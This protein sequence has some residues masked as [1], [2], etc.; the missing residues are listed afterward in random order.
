MTKRAKR[1]LLCTFILL[2]VTLVISATGVFAW[3]SN[4]LRIHTSDSE[5]DSNIGMRINLLFD[6]L[7]PA[8]FARGETITFPDGTT[9]TFDPDA[10][11]GTEENPYI[12]SLPRHMINLYA[13]QEA[14]YFY[15]RYISKNYENGEYIEDSNVKPYF[16]VCETD[17]TPAC[18]DGTRN[19]QSIVI[20]PVGN[21]EYP[22]IGC[23]GGAQVKLDENEQPTTTTAPNGKTSISSIIANFTVEA[24]EDTPDIGLFGKIGYLGEE[25]ENATEGQTFN[26]AVSGVSDLLLYDVKI[27]ST[28]TTDGARDGDHLWES[29]A[30]SNVR[31]EEDH[32]VGIL[33]GHIEYA[34]IRNISVYYSSA[35][36]TAI[37][38][39]A[40]ENANYLSDS[41][42]I[43]LVYNLN[44]ETSGN[45]IGCATGTTIAGSAKGAGNEWGASIDML[46]MYN[47]LLDIQN[48]HSSSAYN[49]T[50]TIIVNENILIGGEPQVTETTTTG[51]MTSPFTGN[52]QTYGTYTVKNYTNEALGSITFSDRSGTNQYLYLHDN[53][54]LTDVVK[55]TYKTDTEAAFFLSQ[56]GTYLNTN[57]AGSAVTTAANNGQNTK[58]R[59]TSDGYLRTEILGEWYYLNVAGGSLS[60]SKTASTAWTVNADGTVRCPAGFLR[61]DGSGWGLTPID[62]Y[63]Y[64]TDGSHYLSG[65]ANAVTNAASAAASVKWSLSNPGGNTA[66]SAYI[67][68]ATRYLTVTDGALAMGGSAYTWNKDGNVYYTTIQGIRHNLVYDNGWRLVPASGHKITDGSGHYLT[69]TANA[70]GN[71]SQSDALVWQF[72]NESGNTQISAVAEGQTRYLTVS[73]GA[74]TV[75]GT[76]ATWTRVGDSFYMTEGGKDYYLNHNGSEWTVSTLSYFTINDGSGNYLRVTGANAFANG[77]AVNATHFYFANDA[78]ANSSGR[79]YC[80]VGGT[81]YYLYNNNGTLATTTTQNTGTQWLNDGSS[82]YVTSTANNVTTTYAIEYDANWHIRT[83]A[84][85]YRITDGNGN[86]MTVS[87]TTIGSTTDPDQATAFEFSTGGANPA[88]TIRVPGTNYY[89]RNNNGTLQVSTTSTTWTNNGTRLYY[90]DWWSSYYLGYYNGAWQLTT[91]TSVTSSSYRIS[92]T[93][94]GVTHYLCVD[95]SGNIFDSTTEADAALWSG[96][97]GTIHTVVNGTTYYLHRV[98][99]SSF[100]VSTSE[101]TS[102]TG[103]NNRLSYNNRYLS[104][105]DGWYMNSTRNNTT[106]AATTSLVSSETVTV[107]S[108]A[109]AVSVVRPTVYVTPESAPVPTVTVTDHA[110]PGTAV[111]L[112]GP[113]KEKITRTATTAPLFVR[114]EYDEPAGETYYP[115]TWEANENGGDPPYV[116]SQKNTGYVISGGTDQRGDI[117][118]SYYAKNNNIS[119]SLTYGNLDDAKIYTYN[120]NGRRTIS[121]VGAAN[122]VKY[123]DAKSGFQETLDSDNTNVYGLHFM[124]APISASNVV[125]APTAV[126]NGE[127]YHDYTMPKDCID[128]RLRTKGYINFFAGTY[129]PDNSTFFSLHQITRDDDG[130]ITSIKEISKIYG[131]PGNEKK[132]YIYQFVGEAAPTLPSG[133]E[134]IFD[135]TWVTN[136]SSNWTDN[137]IYYYEIPVNGGE[138]A[139]GSVSGRDGAYLMYLDIG[140]SAADRT[141]MLGTID[142]VYDN[143]VR[144]GNKIVVVPDTS[145]NDT[146]LDYYQPS[147]AIMYTK[148]NDEDNE[149]DI[150]EFTVTVTRTID[151]A[152]ATNATLTSDFGGGDAEHLNVVPQHSGGDTIVI[153]T[154]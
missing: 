111:T 126:I 114:E 106:Y 42:I 83:I 141:S 59:L 109:Q 98:S 36:V 101:T 44:P 112:D 152:G 33:A 93:V 46:T 104:Y 34:S 4:M 122:L 51:T 12:I 154:S 108:Q 39:H 110:D 153:T 29:D 81:T 130:N 148:N 150:N 20:H 69:A 1:S 9:A 52:T 82:L 136:P 79:A 14:G 91:N 28:A 100:N 5:T 21:D 151:S 107:A 137:A 25:P 146:S 74:L 76:A 128:F 43:G 71:A 135:M 143:T 6:R 77:N 23:V 125:T 75:S 138:Y 40:G 19:G 72:S 45:A 73:N 38:V 26:G 2:L 30:S 15:D 67:G 85:T 56:N 127:T 18:V 92:R 99:N 37:D 49:T 97:S 24:D 57:A 61:Y 132:A 89:L 87:G 60:V 134:Q 102:W 88:G 129:F 41:G 103:S 70:V 58:W 54:K 22:F 131:V 7:N 78:G 48:N 147:L 16:L 8:T 66:I 13:L 50:K 31:Y 90:D 32:H 115:L 120:G 96:N 10:D 118:V 84:P 133:Y 113:H 17:G 94:N 124:N 3:L 144:G 65:T 123:A 64:I 63:Y 68:G 11:W 139:L 140:T 105:R 116:V 145:V 27:V 35:D 53:N 95:S 149:V 55:V 119:A 80:V 117:R 142:F 62:T 47:N 121:Q 86:Y